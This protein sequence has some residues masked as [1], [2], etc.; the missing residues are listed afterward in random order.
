[1]SY[2]LLKL[3]FGGVFFILALTLIYFVSDFFKKRVHANRQCGVAGI[4]AYTA[5]EE[6]RQY[7][8]VDITYPVKMRT[9]QGTIEAE[10][11]N[12]SLG[13]AFICC[14]QPLSLGENFGLTIE[15]PD[16]QPLTVNAEVV[17]SNIN[18]PDDR[19][20]NRG[21]GIRFLQIKKDDG[22]F[23]NE[24]ISANIRNGEE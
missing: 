3:G 11:K 15:A 9:S 24:V 23:L 16:H 18:V 7:S 2:I 20:V 14:R 8:R 21:M 12:I 6:K 22:R 17:W 19:I 4:P 1:M 5:G 13:G 10:T